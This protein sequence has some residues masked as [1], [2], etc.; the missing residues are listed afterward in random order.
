MVLIQSESESWANFSLRLGRIDDFLAVTS[1]PV[2]AMSTTPGPAIPPSS[3]SQS[4]SNGSAS[5]S[6]YPNPYSKTAPSSS[7][8]SP[9][10]EA[11]SSQQVPSHHQ[12][13]LQDY[14]QQKGRTEED[15]GIMKA[16]AMR[17]DTRYSFWRWR[18]GVNAASLGSQISCSLINMRSSIPTSMHRLWIMR[19]W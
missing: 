13:M 2:Q 3:Y 15:K 6:Y 12:T 19:M 4:Q 5:T 1:Q 14:L 16:T 10:T 11:T 8:S 18:D 9:V 7:S 17:Y